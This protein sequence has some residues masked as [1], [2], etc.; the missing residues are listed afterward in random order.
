MFNLKTTT[1][2]K[3]TFPRFQHVEK[4]DPDTQET[5]IIETDDL[6]NHNPLTQSDVS[7]ENQIASGMLSQSSVTPSQLNLVENII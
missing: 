2:R 5:S 7:F 1:A 6:D 4:T 3:Q